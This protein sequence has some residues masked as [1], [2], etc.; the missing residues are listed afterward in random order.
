MPKL[1]IA[2]VLTLAL[3]VPATSEAQST[4]G[5][6]PDPTPPAETNV[7]TLSPRV[8]A[9]PL[10]LV[11]RS[12]P[13]GAIGPFLIQT[14]VVDKEGLADLPRVVGAEE[15]RVIAGA[16]AAIYASG[17]PLDGPR[18]W[19]IFRQGPALQDPD[20]GDVLAYD[21][22][23]IGEAKVRESG[24]PATLDIIRALMEV[25]VDDRLRPAPEI[26]AP[27]LNPR[28]PA[29][30]VR[31]SIVSVRGAVSDFAQYAV[32]VLNIGA[33]DGLEPGHVLA[34]VRRGQLAHRPRAARPSLV[35]DLLGIR[36]E[37]IVPVVDWPHG[38]PPPFPQPESRLPDERNGVVLIFKA[39]ERLSYGIVLKSARPI[40]VG[41]LVVS[42]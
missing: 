24:D 41:D 21:T 25:H 7:V 8:R 17:I 42:P 27:S 10:S 22:I 34:S 1:I 19:Q 38:L 32:V 14:M 31:G 36:D 26:T 33:R 16:G 15:D 30:A 18:T 6:A 29:A 4:P 13:S 37:Q 23:H 35:A 11:P 20:T 3:L 28:A 40:S 2:F 39:L 5:A 12:I 9:E